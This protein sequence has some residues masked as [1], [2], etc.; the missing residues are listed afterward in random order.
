MEAKN[1]K[2]GQGLGKEKQGRQQS[3]LRAQKALQESVNVMYNLVRRLLT[4]V[5]AEVVEGIQITVL[6]DTVAELSCISGQMR[7]RSQEANCT[8]STSPL[9]AIRE[10]GAFGKGCKRITRQ[11]LL[12]VTLMLEFQ[13]CC[14]VVPELGHE[15]IFKID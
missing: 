11:A 9:P 6:L 2:L 4:E 12:E 14:V 3:I 15:M 10:M 7:A 8:L 5:V 1:W 13:V